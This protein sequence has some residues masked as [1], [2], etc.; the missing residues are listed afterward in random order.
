[1]KKSILLVFLL[2]S[3]AA[4]SQNSKKEFHNKDISQMEKEAKKMFKGKLMEKLYVQDTSGFSFE[5]A[6]PSNIAE[7]EEKLF[8]IMGNKKYGLNLFLPWIGDDGVSTIIFYK[9]NFI[10][11]IVHARSGNKR[12]IICIAFRDDLI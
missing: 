12:I 4:F 1:M 7:F 9:E 10:Y 3:F 2:I 11:S 5:V 8:S 6:E